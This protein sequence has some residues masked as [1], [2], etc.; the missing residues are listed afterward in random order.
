MQLNSSLEALALDSPVNRSN[1]KTKANTKNARAS[2]PNILNFK[3]ENP[4]KVKV[5]IVILA[6]FKEGARL[7]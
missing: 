5:K 6:Y 7:S 2:M 4:L 1:K 3:A